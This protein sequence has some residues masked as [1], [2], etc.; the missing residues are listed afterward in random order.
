[1]ALSLIPSS[2]GLLSL[3]QGGAPVGEK[4]GLA[5]DAAAWSMKRFPSN[6][7]SFLPSGHENM[8]SKQK[9]LRNR[10]YSSVSYV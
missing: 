4:L 3:L 5:K 7:L 6:D 8:P 1:M 9:A 2:Q 10:P